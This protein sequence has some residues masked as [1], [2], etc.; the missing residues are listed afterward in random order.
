[1]TIL[2]ALSLCAHLIA[3]S[4]RHRRL[5][6]HTC[7]F[8]RFS[9]VFLWSHGRVEVLPACYVFLIC[10]LV[11]HAPTRTSLPDISALLSGWPKT[12]ARHSNSCRP[13]P[14]SPRRRAWP[15]HAFCARL[16]RIT[17]TTRP[18]CR[19]VGTMR[20]WSVSPIVVSGTTGRP[21]PAHLSPIAH[22]PLD[23]T[24]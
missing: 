10:C 18:S 7:P 13:L 12:H 3:R 9:P 5:A 20:G 1:M 15:P 22:F 19:H 8:S 14:A 23:I 21:R 6:Q 16:D 2:R 4:S 24:A 11:L 17:S